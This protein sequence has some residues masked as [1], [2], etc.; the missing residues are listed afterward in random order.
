N[1]SGILDE[2]GLGDAAKEGKL[3]EVWNKI[4]L[5][6]PAARQSLKNAAARSESGATCVSAMTGEGIDELLDVVARKLS[7]TN[8]QMELTLDASEGALANWLHEHAEIRSRETRDN[9]E[10]FY[11]FTISPLNRE[12]LATRLRN[13]TATPASGARSGEAA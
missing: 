13:R 11:R 6:D 12:R 3:L 7:D 9:G 10:T 1:V 2:L 5:L 4:D 8:S